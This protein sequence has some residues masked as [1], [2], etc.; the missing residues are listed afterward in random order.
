MLS[1]FEEEWQVSLPDDFRA[2]LRFVGNGCGGPYFGISPI[3]DWSQPYDPSELPADFLKTP[4]HPDQ[5]RDHGLTPGALRI[6]NAG[7]EHYYLLVVSGPFRGQVWHDADVDALGVRALNDS[8]GQPLLFAEWIGEWLDVT[9][10]GLHFIDSF[11][12]T[13]EFPGHAVAQVLSSLREG[14][15]TVAAEQLPCWACFR[16]LV[17][18]NARQRMIVTSLGGERLENPKRAAMLAAEG[19]VQAVPRVAFP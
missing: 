14:G 11:W 15:G 10:R 3:E 18:S 12:G 6:C 4:Y 9:S 13:A 1:R 2:L 7:C 8:S 16:L 17:E 19:R 5:P